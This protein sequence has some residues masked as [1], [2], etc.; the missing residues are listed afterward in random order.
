[1]SDPAIN[2]ARLAG[3]PS[4]TGIALGAKSSGLLTIAVNGLPVTMQA[5][6]DVTFAAGDR[7]AWVRVGSAS[8][9]MGRVGTTTVADQPDAALPPVANPAEVVGVRTFQP[10]ETR[11]RQGTR[12]RTDTLSVYQGE[13][14]A[15]GNHVGCA[16]YGDAFGSLAGATVESA[17]VTIRRTMASGSSAALPLTLWLVTE[18]VR[19][20]GAPTLTDDETGPLL[21]WGQE[22]Q[23]TIP[24]AWAQAMVDGTA[25]GLALYEAD[26]A[27]YLATQ[28]RGASE[29]A[30]ALT[31][32]WRR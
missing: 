14:A 4:G 13:T 18:T 30:W 16:F 26:G 28:G 5:A 19:P 17:D 20:A 27:P 12:W 32:N 11:S 2:R 1:M 15:A 10:V 22:S 29:S 24:T 7:V 31:V 23:F 6:R 3:L 8:F 21:G 25:G 9:V